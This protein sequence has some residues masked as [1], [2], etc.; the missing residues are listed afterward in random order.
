MLDKTTEFI[1]IHKDRYVFP[2]KLT[3]SHLSGAG[4]DSMFMGM[5]EVRWDGG[6]GFQIQIGKFP[7]HLSVA[8]EDSMFMGI[9]A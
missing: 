4:E 8:G 7:I 2:V 6:W 3:V 1:A 5:I 9:W